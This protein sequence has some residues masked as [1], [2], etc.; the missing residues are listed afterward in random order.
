MRPA[1]SLYEEGSTASEGVAANERLSVTGLPVFGENDKRECQWMP[2][3]VDQMAEVPEL[4]PYADQPASDCSRS[5]EKR[6]TP[7]G[8]DA[9]PFGIQPVGLEKLEVSKDAGKANFASKLSS[10]RDRIRQFLESQGIH[11]TLPPGQ[12]VDTLEFRPSDAGK[13]RRERIPF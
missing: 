10:V 8:V 11:D 13:D 12:A 6:V 1:C 5:L 7:S 3:C 4:M 9:N 2:M